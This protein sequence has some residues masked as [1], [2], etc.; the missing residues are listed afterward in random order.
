[1]GAAPLAYP[2]SD[3][4]LSACENAT[5]SLARVVAVMVSSRQEASGGAGIVEH[6]AEFSVTPGI[7]SRISQN[8]VMNRTVIYHPEATAFCLLELPIQTC[9]VGQPH[10][11]TRG[12]GRLRPRW[13]DTPPATSR[14]H[15]AVGSARALELAAPS[16]VAADEAA[17]EELARSVKV[18]LEGMRESSSSGGFGAGDTLVDVSRTTT[19]VAM[20]GARVL[21]RWF[22]ED[23][24]EYHSL[25]AVHIDCARAVR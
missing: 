13:V 1:M 8:A 7:K 2:E 4:I 6:H 21:A 24:N 3:A 25:A 14:W 5:A 16:L 11:G 17:L 12:K 20:R 9:G 10:I 15:V 22:D 19:R 23:E 18:K